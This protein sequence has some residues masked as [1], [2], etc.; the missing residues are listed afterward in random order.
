[1]RLLS[2]GLLCS[3]MHSKLLSAVCLS[4]C[5]FLPGVLLKPRSATRAAA[6]L[7]ERLGGKDAVNAAVDKFYEKV[8]E[9][10]S[11]WESEAWR[12]RCHS[13]HS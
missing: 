9:R 5:V 3:T 10:G 6:T 2:G 11:P 1:M 4:L 13:A 8:C 12:L 7:Y